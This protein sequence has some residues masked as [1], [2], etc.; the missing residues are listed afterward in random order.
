MLVEILEQPDKSYR[1]RATAEGEVV[2]DVPVDD[3]QSACSYAQGVAAGYDIIR[4]LRARARVSYLPAALL[5]HLAQTY[6]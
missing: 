4:G 6:H 3:Y 5:P 2:L 1:V